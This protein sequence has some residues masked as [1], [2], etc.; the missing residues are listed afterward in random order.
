[1]SPQFSKETR[2][3][4]QYYQ[5]LGIIYKR[6]GTRLYLPEPKYHLIVWYEKTP[7][8]KQEI[9][10]G[11]LLC[12]LD[13]AYGSDPT[14]GKSTTGFSFQFYGG[15]VKYKSKTQSINALS[16]IEAEL[17]SDVTSD[18][19]NRLL[20]PLLQGLGFTHDSPTPIYEDNY[21]TIYI[22]NSSIPTEI[23]CHI[24]FRFSDIQGY[25]EAGD[26]IIH[27]IPGTINPEDDLT[28]HLGLVLYS[29]HYRYLMKHY[30]ISFV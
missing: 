4:Y 20:M 6:R 28:K 29:G 25:K 12:F 22:V 23:T 26:I 27:L 7:K 14:K 1:M 21:P 2:D 11:E 16:S 19:T 8:H 30:N 9:D 18:N 13:A 15:E 5:R 10:N 3:I 24:D 17:I